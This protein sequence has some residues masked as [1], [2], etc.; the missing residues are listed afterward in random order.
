M[1]RVYLDQNKWIDLARARLGKN[2]AAR[3]VLDVAKE[4]VR[5]G[6]ASF[7]L[8][9]THYI[10][11]WNSRSARRRWN[12]ASTMFNLARPGG[13]IGPHT[14]AGPPEVVEMELDVALRRRFGRP[15]DIR[16]QPVF[17]EGVG[18]AFG[19]PAVKYEAPAELPLSPERRR[20][21][22]YQASRL[23]ELVSLAGPITDLP[24]VG[25]DTESYKRPSRTYMEGEAGRVELFKRLRLNRDKRAK[26]VGVVSLLD[27]F[28]PLN[29]ALSR[30]G[31]DNEEF[32]SLSADEMM[33][34]LSDLPSRH[35]DYELHR[36][37]HEDPHLK[38]GLGDL[39]DLAALSVAIAYCDV[40][41]TERLWAHLARRAGLE[42]RYETRILSNVCDL[43]PLLL[44]AK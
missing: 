36:L 40:V 17:G 43:L 9:S 20:D 30:A 37:R 39:E 41:V 18:H 33:D 2:E 13:S 34:F 5:L 24:V 31:I 35:V 1:L 8:S 42:E 15:L 32:L 44:I 21:I 11:T 16:W 27:I 38:R 6:L 4:A 14:M 28:E 7:P 3:D 10:E 22:N 26:Y 23:K 19:K 25:I 29:E 12:L